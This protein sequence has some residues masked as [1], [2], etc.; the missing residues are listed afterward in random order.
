[1]DISALSMQAVSVQP[2][3]MISVAMFKKAMET[4][5]TNGAEMIQMMERSVQPNL[6]Q[7]IDIKL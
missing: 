6:G 3:D 2:N 7:N 1:M 4:V 5:E